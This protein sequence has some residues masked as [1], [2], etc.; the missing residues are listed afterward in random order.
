MTQ[1]ESTQRKLKLQMKGN[2]ELYLSEVPQDF[3]ALQPKRHS[4]SV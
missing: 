1:Q 4:S 2:K 3:E